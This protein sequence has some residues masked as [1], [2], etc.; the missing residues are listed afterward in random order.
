MAAALREPSP[1]T[2]RCAGHALLER[3]AAAHDGGPAA[4]APGAGRS[5]AH[6]VPRAPRRHVGAGAQRP[7]RLSGQ[8]RRVHAR[9]HRHHMGQHL[10][11]ALRSATARGAGCGAAWPRTL[12]S[13]RHARRCGSVAGRAACRPG[14]R[15]CCAQHAA[16]A[17]ACAGLHQRSKAAGG[18]GAAEGRPV[19]SRRVR[20]HHTPLLQGGGRAGSRRKSSAVRAARREPPLRGCT[21]SCGWRASGAR[22]CGGCGRRPACT[23][24]GGG[25]GLRRR[26]RRGG[27][28]QPA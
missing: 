1:G 8:P 4:V 14:A 11:C 25:R 24:A 17:L 20:K 23:G 22:G 16:R 3:T 13:G 27:A 19:R 12:A 18:A 5:A 9:T 26:R 7:A 28:K 21:G 10:E 2:H 6:L 15:R